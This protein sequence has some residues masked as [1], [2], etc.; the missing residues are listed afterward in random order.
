MVVLHTGAGRDFVWMELLTMCVFSI[1]C[2]LNCSTEE[3]E[4]IM[5]DLG[6]VLRRRE[7]KIVA[8]DFNAKNVA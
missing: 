4:E 5:E 6:R 1:Y 7:D 8:G 3:Y 2:S